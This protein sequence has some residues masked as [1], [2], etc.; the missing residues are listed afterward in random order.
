[1]ITS[2]IRLIWEGTCQNRR[3][4]SEI[5][6]KCL[7]F[8]FFFYLGKV[9]PL[10]RSS[11]K[12]F[13]YWGNSTNSLSHLKTSSWV[14]LWT[15]RKKES[16]KKKSQKR[17]TQSWMETILPSED[18]QPFQSSSKVICWSS[19]WSLLC[20]FA[21]CCCCISSMINYNKKRCRCK[22]V[23]DLNKIPHAR[24][25]LYTNTTNGVS[26]HIKQQLS[27]HSRSKE[28]KCLWMCLGI[29]LCCNQ[30]HH[31]I[32]GFFAASIHLNL[33]Y[34]NKEKKPNARDMDTLQDIT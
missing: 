5:I 21:C 14:Q 2:E 11:L 17:N 32:P 23:A 19:W 13:S 22:R 10:T 29:C 15:D 28:L 30:M 26:P 3:T 24:K 16:S 4:N 7:F 33:F 27:K 20:L 31:V 12:P 9:F 1:M 6:L 34:S 8:F 25:P 18:F